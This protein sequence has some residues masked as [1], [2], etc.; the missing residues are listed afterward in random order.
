MNYS[1]KWLVAAAVVIGLAGSNAWAASFQDLVISV[2]PVPNVTLTL[3]GNTA[4]A[5][6]NLDVGTSTVSYSAAHLTNTGNVDVSATSQITGNTGN[7]MASLSSGTVD[8]YTLYVATSATTPNPNGSE[9]NPGT[10]VTAPA[11]PV[12]LKGL[13]GSTAPNMAATTGVLDLWFRLDM[14]RQVSTTAARSMTVRFT[15][16][17]VSL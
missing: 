17:A 11:T 8:N 12:A 16:T 13:S 3:T 9:F 7:W 2:T 15:A 4:W 6:G 5:I 1:R 14:P 10:A